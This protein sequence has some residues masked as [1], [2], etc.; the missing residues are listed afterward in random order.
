[1]FSWEEINRKR[2][3]LFTINNFGYYE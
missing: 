3:F 2:N 1:M